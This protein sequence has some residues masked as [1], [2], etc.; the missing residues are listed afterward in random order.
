MRYY[1]SGVPLDSKDTKLLSSDIFHEFLLRRLA[2]NKV[3]EREHNNLRAETTGVERKAKI[4]HMIS[5]T[6]INKAQF[7]SGIK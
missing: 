6:R 1:F 2:E 3:L 4:S 7:I 5:V